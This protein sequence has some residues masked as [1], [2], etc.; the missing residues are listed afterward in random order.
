MLRM[1]WKFI[2]EDS[3]QGWER[4]RD[5]VAYHERKKRQK[6]NGDDLAFQTAAIAAVL[7]H[8]GLLP[9]KGEKK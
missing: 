2:R 9:K 8:L 1:P 7:Y 6:R 3:R 5:R 4:E